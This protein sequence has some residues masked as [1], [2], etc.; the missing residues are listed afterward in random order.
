[1]TDSEANSRVSEGPDNAKTVE[2]KFQI[3][4]DKLKKEKV[5]FTVWGA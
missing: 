5:V 2:W 3:T 4:I 1:M